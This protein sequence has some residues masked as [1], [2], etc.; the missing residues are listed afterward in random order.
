MLQSVPPEMLSTLASKA[1]A[2][3]AWEIVKT[4]RLGSSRV[5][6]AKAVTLPRR[7]EPVNFHGGEGIDDFGMCL[8]SLVMQLD[9]PGDKIG[10]P[11]IVRKFLSVVLRAYS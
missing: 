3:D 6:E 7:Y 2:K 8:S 5:R 1:T 4:M 11:A 10:E 9:L